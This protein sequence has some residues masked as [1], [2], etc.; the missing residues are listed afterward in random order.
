[1]IGGS[2]ELVQRSEI[3]TF[4]LSDKQKSREFGFRFMTLSATDSLAL[5]VESIGA[6][7]IKID[8]ADLVEI[9]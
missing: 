6:S 2:R 4:E 7:R 8:S 1:M 3:V 9:R 5:S